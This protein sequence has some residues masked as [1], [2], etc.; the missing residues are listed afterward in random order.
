MNIREKDFLLDLVCKVGVRLDDYNTLGMIDLMRGNARENKYMDSLLY[1][2]KPYMYAQNEFR[3]DFLVNAYVVDS[4]KQSYNVLNNTLQEELKKAEKKNSYRV[5]D[6]RRAIKD[7]KYY[8][9]IINLFIE[10][11]KKEDRVI[12]DRGYVH[13]ILKNNQ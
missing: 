12:K 1:L 7:I 2:L 13:K 6:Y 8:M 10:L 3:S 4:I 9:D 11:E 5:E